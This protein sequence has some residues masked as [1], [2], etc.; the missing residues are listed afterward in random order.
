MNK[1]EKRSDRTIA[2]RQAKM[3]TI[4]ATLTRHLYVL[5]EVI[6][7]L[8]SACI[9]G[10][11]QEA[12]FWLQELIDSEELGWAVATLV[13][14]CIL[15]YGVHGIGWLKEAYSCFEGEEIGVDEL[16]AACADLCGLENQDHSLVAMHL[17]RVR[18]LGRGEVPD[19]ITSEVVASSSPLHQ[20]FMAALYQGK[21]RAAFWAS[22]GMSE[23]DLEAVS[24]THLRAHETG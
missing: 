18:D 10:R 8:R 23:S 22:A 21:A 7:G 15:Y 5:D 2:D 11:R 19:Y 12:A 17:L 13:E 3:T 16:H 1:I 6:G 4:P 9:A 24:Y 14:T 20:Y